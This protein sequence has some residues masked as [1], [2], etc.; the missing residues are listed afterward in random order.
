MPLLFKRS[1]SYI[2]MEMILFTSFSN[3]IFEYQYLVSNY[4]TKLYEQNIIL[5]NIL[6]F[7]LFQSTLN[8]K[9]SPEIELC[10][11]S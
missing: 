6:T 10:Q 3:R 1:I 9:R 4:R 2:D 11:E 8:L 5:L 7:A